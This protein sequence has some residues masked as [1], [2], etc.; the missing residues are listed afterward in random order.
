MTI[1]T[2]ANEKGGVGKTTLATTL[3]AGMAARGHQVL[4]VDADP[5]ANATIAVGA[6][7]RPG[8]YDLLIRDAAWHEVIMQVPSK[9]YNANPQQPSRLYLLPGNVETRNIAS[10]ISDVFAITNR[11]QELEGTMELIII[12]TSPTPSLLHG[13]IYLATDGIIYPTT[14][15]ALAFDGLIESLRHREEANKVR[16]SK[17]MAAFK[18]LGIVPTLYRHTKEHEDNLK[19]LKAAFPGLVWEPLPQRTIWTEAARKQLSV[20]TFDPTSQAAADGH[21]LVEQAERAIYA[22]A[23]A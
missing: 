18:T 10:S 2:L 15:E 1:I 13:S 3:A 21:K 20:F 19:D 8:I 9:Y 12:D 11:L 7:K 23:S 5:Q 16:N 22:I 4:L 6:K 17:N 14:C